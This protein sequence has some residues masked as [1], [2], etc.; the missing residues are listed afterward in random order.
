MAI[1][2]YTMAA[3]CALLPQPDFVVVR[4]GA[5]A[6]TRCD[7]LNLTTTAKFLVIAAHAFANATGFA[8]VVIPANTRLVDD[9]AFANSS[10]ISVTLLNPA[11]IVGP[12]AF[13]DLKQVTIACPSYRIT[14]S[15]TDNRWHEA[16]QGL[17]KC[18][19]LKP[20]GIYDDDISGINDIKDLVLKSSLFEDAGWDKQTDD[21]IFAFN[22]LG[23]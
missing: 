1:I 20:S 11:T 10:V 17:A 4:P 13:P 8:E 16:L 7:I 23:T 6:N 19:H 21:T 9:H 5:F 12:L 2:G 3:R 22:G 15:I 18:D 14:V